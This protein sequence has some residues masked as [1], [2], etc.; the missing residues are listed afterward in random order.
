MKNLLQLHSYVAL[1]TVPP[2]PVEKKNLTF[3]WEKMGPRVQ[4]EYFIKQNGWQK[5]HV[6]KQ[7]VENEIKYAF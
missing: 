7:H 4:L 5:C 2:I 3:T 6:R 1:S